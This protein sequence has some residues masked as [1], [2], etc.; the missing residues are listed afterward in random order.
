MQV[1]L[2]KTLL[3]EGARVGTIDKF[4]SGYRLEQVTASGARTG[5]AFYETSACTATPLRTALRRAEIQ[6]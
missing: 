3:P 1:N 5:R 2:L 6:Y 4:Q